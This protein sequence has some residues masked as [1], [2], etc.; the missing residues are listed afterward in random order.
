MERLVETAAH[1]MGINKV[2]LRR[3]NHIQ[4]W[5][6]PYKAPSGMLTVAASFLPSWKRRLL[7][8][9]G[10]DTP[11]AS[12]HPE[13]GAKIRGRGMG[14]YLEVTADVGNEM[15]G[16]R[17]EG[18]GDVTII[19]GTLDYGQGHVTPFAQVLSA[20]LGV[21]FKKIRLLQGDSDELGPEAVPAGHVR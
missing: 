8:P 18:N 20:R 10:T 6:M 9:T 15:G 16:I 11:R 17:F 5:Q 7:P 3:R 19:T 4:P 21:P 1:E 2:E 12:R 13:L 14:H